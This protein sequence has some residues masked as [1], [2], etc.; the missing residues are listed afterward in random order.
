MLCD[1]DGDGDVLQKMKL[2]FEKGKLKRYQPH[3][4]H[5]QDST[6]TV[7]QYNNKNMASSS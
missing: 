7:F 3:K 6:F 5:I 1:D 2:L 4:K